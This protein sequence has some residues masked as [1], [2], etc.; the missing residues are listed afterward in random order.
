MKVMT[1][2]CIACAEE[3]MSQAK[4]CKHCK[5]VQNDERFSNASLL[6]GMSDKKI[7]PECA[8][9]TAAGDPR[10]SSC[11]S[12][13]GFGSF[14]ETNAGK[15]IGWFES[16]GVI[17]ILSELITTI[18]HTWDCY[19]GNRPCGVHTEVVADHWVHRV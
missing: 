5:T 7:C 18:D 11:F 1:K 17:K 15:A 4:L 12:F 16:R 10:C 6:T 3:I 19:I 8:S 9:A 13:I 2:T 14:N